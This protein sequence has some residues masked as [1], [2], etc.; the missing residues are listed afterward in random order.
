M[1]LPEDVVSFVEVW[2]SDRSYFV[3]IDGLNTCVVDLTRGTI[4]GSLLGPIL[5]AIYVLPLFDL[6]DIKNFANNN[7]AIGWNDTIPE[8]IETIF[9]WL[10]GSGLIVNES[11]YG[12]CLSHRKDHHPVTRNLNGRQITYKNEINAL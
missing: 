6:T 4:Q 2:L 12:I 1:G 5:H 3:S 8:L 9:K 10:K 7:F 11:K